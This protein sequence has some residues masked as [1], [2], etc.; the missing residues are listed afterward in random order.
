[1]S[2]TL[3]GRL[4]KLWHSSMTMVGVAAGGF[5]CAGACGCCLPGGGEDERSHEPGGVFAD[6]AFGQAGEQDAAAVEYVAHVEGGVVG[7]QRA[8][9]ELAEQ[10]G[11]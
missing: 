2:S 5:G 3:P 4:R 6:L 10:E 8:A 9:G 11:A 7:A 1:M